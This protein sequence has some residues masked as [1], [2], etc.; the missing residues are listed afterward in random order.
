[1]ISD[2]WKHLTEDGIGKQKRWIENAGGLD[3]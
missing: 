2:M 1:M 3:V